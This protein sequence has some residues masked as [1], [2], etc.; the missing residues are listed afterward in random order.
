[1]RDVPQHLASNAR[2]KISHLL[3][4]GRP[5]PTNLPPNLRKA[6]KSLKTNNN[7]IILPADEGKATVVI[8]KVDIEDMMH[9]T[10]S[11][12][13]TYCKVDKNPTT[14]LERK[15]NSLLLQLRKKGLPLYERLRL[16]VGVMAFTYGLPKIH[17]PYTPL[18]PIVSFHTSSSYQL[19]K[20][21]VHIL[22][23]SFGW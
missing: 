2:K 9:I 1:M 7:I 4:K 13:K 8:N 18:R 6:V 10:L 21:L 22:A 11:D 23:H 17:K 16:T 14:S 19:S 3:V 20:H 5:P 15:L 12:E